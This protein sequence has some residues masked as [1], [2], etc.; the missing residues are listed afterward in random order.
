MLR[1]VFLKPSVFEEN[2]MFLFTGLARNVFCGNPFSSRFI[3]YA[4]EVAGPTDEKCHRRLGLIASTDRPPGLRETTR[5]SRGEK[6]KEIKRGK[7]V[8]DSPLIATETTEKSI[9]FARMDSGI[10]DIWLKWM[11]IP[12]P[13]ARLCKKRFPMTVRWNL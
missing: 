7:N 5:I 2:K 9:L 11:H 4:N 3:P 6:E 8:R 13:R 1:E 10:E 12:T